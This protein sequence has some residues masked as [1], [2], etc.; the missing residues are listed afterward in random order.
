MLIISLK[1][2]FE[3]D[4]YNLKCIISNEDSKTY[5]ARETPKLQLV[6]DL[7]A[8]VMKLKKITAYLGKKYPDGENVKRL[9]TTLTK[10]IVEILYL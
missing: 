6:A 1:I 5:C 4:A 9:A 2:Y 3:S 10:K 8:R 7:L